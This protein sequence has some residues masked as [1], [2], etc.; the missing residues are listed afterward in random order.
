MLWRWKLLFLVVLLLAPGVAYLIVH[1]KPRVYQ[2]STLV[3]VSAAAVN[4]PGSGGGT[5][6]TS[7]IAAIARLVNTSQ[8]ADIAAKRLNPPANPAAIAGDVSATS[9]VTTDFIT[10]TAQAN[11]PRRAAAIANA[12]A[13]AL[14]TNRT[15][16]AIGQ[17][18]VQI[19]ALQR[20]LD[21]TP[22]GPAGLAARQSLQQQLSQLRAFRGSQGGNVA[23]IQAAAPNPTPVSPHVRRTVELGLVIGLLLAIGAVALAE[24]SD[25]RLRS[26]SDLEELTRLPLLSAIPSRAFSAAI[27]SMD[28][29][30]ESFQMLRSALTY[31]NVDRRLATVVLTSPG[32]KDGKTTVA[33]RLAMASARAGKNVLLVDADL[34][35]NQII[36]RLGIPAHAGLGAVLVREKALSD[37]LLDYPVDSTNGGRLMILPAGPPPP[38]PSEL[39]SSQEMRRLL[40]EL[41]SRADLVI[42]DTPA[43]LS[44]SDA[45]PLLQMASGVVL[46]ARMGRTTREQVKR[47]QRVVLNV[48]GTIVGVVAT[49]VGAGAGYED[50]GH[51]YDLTGEGKDRR[52][53]LRPFGRRKRH[54]TAAEVRL[55]EASPR[56]PEP[57]TRVEYHDA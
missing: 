55:A 49:A 26:P 10:I 37:V 34:R 52:S 39:I 47:L 18:D 44:V 36:E 50:Y 22:P 2:A 15:N 7:N 32:Q 41:E 38:N 8:I 57:S 33:V 30:E 27:D 24:N 13:A 42:I 3:S 9:D 29:E 54:N 5:F 23:V 35:R 45:M 16:A 43:A 14:G 12:F 53:R 56:H 46:V 11:D 17:L 1:N 25:R 4:T 31:F 21:A 40:P 48:H 19:G 28:T 51:A 20:Q 6:A